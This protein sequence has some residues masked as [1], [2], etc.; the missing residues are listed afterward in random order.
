MATGLHFWFP[1]ISPPDSFFWTRLHYNHRT[2]ASTIIL[3]H[4]CIH[5]HKHVQGYRNPLQSML[6]SPVTAGALSLIS[7]FTAFQEVPNLFSFMLHSATRCN[8]SLFS[9]TSLSPLKK[10]KKKKLDSQHSSHVLQ[11]HMKA[12][13]KKLTLFLTTDQSSSAALY[14]CVFQF[15][16]LWFKWR[17]CRAKG[18]CCIFGFPWLLF[19]KEIKHEKL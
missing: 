7:I 12:G 9:S 5:N 14:A 2:K 11:I 4:L 8:F 15:F 17:E 19:K 13:G 3:H 1:F 10:K 18:Y 16:F 6:R